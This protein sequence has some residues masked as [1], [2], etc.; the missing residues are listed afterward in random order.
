[1]M[2]MKKRF[3]SEIK[4]TR[5]SYRA[6][7]RSEG[8]SPSEASRLATDFTRREMRSLI[9]SMQSEKNYDWRVLR[10]VCTEEGLFT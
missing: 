2:E 10:D 4:R 8:V 3:R 1:M 6:I 5:A 9:R 7:M